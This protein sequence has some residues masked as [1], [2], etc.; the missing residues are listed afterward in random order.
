MSVSEDHKSW[1]K[2]QITMLELMLTDYE[3]GRRNA[4]YQTADGRKIDETA[5]VISQLR[6][7]IA[8]LRSAA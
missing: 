5:Q 3:A 2:V 7:D 6:Q 8:R 1:L 4:V